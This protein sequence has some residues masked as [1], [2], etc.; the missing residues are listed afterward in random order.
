[1]NK[2]KLLYDVV[3]TMKAKEVI[4]GIFQ[5]EVEKDQVSLFSIQN[6]FEKNLTT[7]KTKAKVTASLDVEGRNERLDHH[8]RLGFDSHEHPHAHFGRHGHF[9][10]RGHHRDL[11]GG[12][13][14]MAFGL[15]ILN[16]LQITEQPDQTLVMTIQSSDLPAEMKQLLAE[17]INHGGL[18]HHP[19]HAIMKELCNLKD[20][21]ST[22]TLILNK[23]RELDKIIITAN[24]TQADPQGVSHKL[25]AKIECA[26]VW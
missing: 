12:F 1:M 24:G 22:T 17:R 14:K 7:G 23:N 19:K 2:L 10:H 6:E 5:A 15:S 18:H 25:N 16:A 21:D 4:S 11:R 3:T 9:F 20:F 8:G 26:F 13:A